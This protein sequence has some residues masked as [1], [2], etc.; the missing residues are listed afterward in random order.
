MKLRESGSVAVKTNHFAPRLARERLALPRSRP[1]GGGR[2][3][4]ERARLFLLTHQALL[5]KYERVDEKAASGICLAGYSLD[6]P[7]PG[8]GA[9]EGMLPLAVAAITGSMVQYGALGANA[10][11]SSA[12]VGTSCIS[13]F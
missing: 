11:L 12:H 4:T 8:R 7:K 6:P 2:V 3:L 10:T 1:A 13:A 5:S 9:S